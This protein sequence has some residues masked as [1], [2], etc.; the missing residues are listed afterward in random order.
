MYTLNL[1]DKTGRKLIYR[2]VCYVDKGW[3]QH[4]LCVILTGFS[5]NTRTY[6]TR[7]TCGRLRVVRV[8]RVWLIFVAIPSPTYHLSRNRT[9]IYINICVYMSKRIYMFICVYLFKSNNNNIIIR[10]AYKQSCNYRSGNECGVIC[11][12]CWMY[13]NFCRH[14]IIMTACAWPISHI[15]SDAL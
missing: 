12:K 5:F 6:Y 9:G 3:V 1:S 8:T 11:E 14:P 4:T 2:I 10:N 13:L 7:A 15:H